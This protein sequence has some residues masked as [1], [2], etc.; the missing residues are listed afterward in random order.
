MTATMH[1]KVQVQHLQRNAYL[2]YT[3]VH[4]APGV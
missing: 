2:I 4:T 1:E 3:T